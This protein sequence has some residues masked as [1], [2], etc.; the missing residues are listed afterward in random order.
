MFGSSEGEVFVTIKGGTNVSNSPSIDY[1]QQVLLPMLS[2]VGL[3]KISLHSHS[4]GW[5]TGRNE[6]GAVTF[7]II[8]VAVGCHLPAFKVTNRG[9]VVRIEATILAS[10]LAKEQSLR[11]LAKAISLAFPDIEL[12][13]QFE[14]SFHPKRLYLLLV[15]TSANGYKL[16]RDWLYDHKVASLETAIPKLVAKVI[17]DLSIELEH[18]GCVDE[19]MR[20]QYVVFQAL[21]MGRS[22]IDGGYRQD[23]RE[24]VEASLHTQT[25]RWVASE[26]LG[27][28]FDERG[29][30]EGIGFVV[31]EKLN[32]RIGSVARRGSSSGES[33]LDEKTA[34]LH[35]DR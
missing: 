14:D 2:I 24:A 12:D 15:A 22:E 28:Q 26:L 32:G 30:C 3:T 6:M 18:G 5:S 23:K 4:R 35:L 27:V 25:A 20:D 31:G 11:E 8:P 9:A 16:G 29:T 1:I 21:A 17:A 33:E 10:R 7:K 19:Y 13:I 34:K